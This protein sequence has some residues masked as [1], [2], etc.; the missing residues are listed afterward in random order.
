[1]PSQ[2]KERLREQIDKSVGLLG[3]FGWGSL[4]LLSLALPDFRNWPE[5][6]SQFG[7]VRDAMVFFRPKIPAILLIGTTIFWLYQYKE[8]VRRLLCIGVSGSAYFCFV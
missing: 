5:F 4:V 7:S 2:I 6:L 3:I 8:A 1:M